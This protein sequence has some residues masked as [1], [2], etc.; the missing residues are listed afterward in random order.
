[1]H[2]KINQRSFLLAA[3]FSLVISIPAFSQ[4]GILQDKDAIKLTRQAIDSIYNLNY[5]A[6]D[7]MIHELEGSLGDYPGVLLLKAFYMSWKYRPIK[8]DQQAFNDFEKLLF[9]SV[10]VCDSLLTIN[11]EDPEATFFKLT[12]HAYLAQLYSDNGMNMKALGEAKEAYTYMKAGFD[13][14]DKNPEFYFPCGIYN[15]YREKYPEE[16]PFYK[17]FMW[18]F[19]SGD[20]SEGIS[21]LKKGMNQALFDNVECITYLFHIYLRYEDKPFMALP[22]ARLLKDTYP[23]NLIYTSHYIENSIRMNQYN[24]LAPLVKKLLAGDKPFFKYLGEIYSGYLAEMVD[25]NYP[26]A[27][28]H[29]KMADKLG[30]MD[31]VRIPNYDSILFYGMGRTY[32]KMGLEDLA[33]TSLKLS[34]KNAEYKSYRTPAEELLRK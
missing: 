27:I 20:M 14:V 10:S 7:K 8:K 4:Y 12:S 25:K 22:Y 16:N 5:P 31:N 6:A 18:L 13:M 24:G 1:L 28:E 19:R 23:Q 2:L 34:V 9:K 26:A 21:M 32:K 29:Y 15:Y 30:D 17:S 11:Q 33:H 3:I